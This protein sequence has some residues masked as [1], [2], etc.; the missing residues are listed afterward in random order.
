MDHAHFLVALERK[1][2]IALGHY[3]VAEHA[4]ETIVGLKA[5]AQADG[6]IQAER[7]RLNAEMERIADAIRRVVDRAWRRRQRE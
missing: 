1:Y 3:E 5:L 4:T 2:A 7:K 6:R